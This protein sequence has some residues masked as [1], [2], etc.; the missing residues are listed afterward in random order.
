MVP[1]ANIPSTVHTQSLNCSPATCPESEQL[2]LCVWTVLGTFALGTI[3]VKLSA[4]LVVVSI[5]RYAV[6]HTPCMLPPH[7][8]GRPIANQP[9][10]EVAHHFDVLSRLFVVTIGRYALVLTTVIKIVFHY[11]LLHKLFQPLAQC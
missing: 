2:E 7:T 5:T 1:K 3:V 8:P 4:E 11:W 6:L 10:P 9:H